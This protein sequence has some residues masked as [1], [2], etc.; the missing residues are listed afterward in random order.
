MTPSEKVQHYIDTLV[1]NPQSELDELVVLLR[2]KS[3]NAEE[4]ECLIAFVPIAFAHAGRCPELSCRFESVV[5]NI[6][7]PS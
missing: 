2:G 1:E 5:M 4:V 7:L 6:M 3:I